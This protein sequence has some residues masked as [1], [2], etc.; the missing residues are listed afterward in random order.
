MVMLH[1]AV[2]VN[3]QQESRLVIMSCTIIHILTAP[4]LE[5]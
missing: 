5:T 3:L 1:T 2:F 4:P